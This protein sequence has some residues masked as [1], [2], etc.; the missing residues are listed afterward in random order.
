[1]PDFAAQRERD[2]AT[3]GSA[4]RQ[5]QNQVKTALEDLRRVIDSRSKRLLNETT[6]DFEKLRELI[7]AK[8]AERKNMKAS[9][10]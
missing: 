9:L 4:S 10:S 6:T 8:L 3:Q 5:R 7:K 2:E 1:M